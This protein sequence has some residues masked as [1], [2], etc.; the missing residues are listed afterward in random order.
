M[1]FMENMTRWRGLPLRCKLREC[2]MSRVRESGVRKITV[3]VY[4]KAIPGIIYEFIKYCPEC[5][6]EMKGYSWCENNESESNSTQI[7]GIQ[8]A[9]V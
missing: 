1:G 3:D 8:R 4:N 6:R 9:R 2:R 7:Q 5:Q